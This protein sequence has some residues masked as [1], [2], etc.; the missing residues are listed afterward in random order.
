MLWALVP[1]FGY[2][3]LSFLFA[4]LRADTLLVI[5]S[6]PAAAAFQVFM[7]LGGHGGYELIIIPSAIMYAV[8][9][10]LSGFMSTPK[11]RI[12]FF[13]ASIGVF[14]IVGWKL[15]RLERSN[16]NSDSDFFRVEKQ[17]KERIP[18]ERA[19]LAETAYSQGAKRFDYCLKAYVRRPGRLIR[20]LPYSWLCSE[21]DV[22]ALKESIRLASPETQSALLCSAHIRLA[23]QY[24]LSH[25][26]SKATE[27]YQKTVGCSTKDPDWT[28]WDN[29]YKKFIDAAIRFETVESNKAR[30]S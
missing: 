13:A 25:K 28:D 14:A 27:S 10:G 29:L 16:W 7:R 30:K 9:G 6:F 8:F 11:R 20:G 2:L 21:Y 1:A 3:L 4:A 12:L 24:A 19:R 26:P 17:W 15:D 18:R 23:A 5:L 22:E